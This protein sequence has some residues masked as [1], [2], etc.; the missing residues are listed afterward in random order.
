M[1]VLLFWARL[2]F[3]VGLYVSL[4][5][6]KVEGEGEGEG[7][8]KEMGWKGAYRYCDLAVRRMRRCTLKTPLGCGILSSACR[9]YRRF[10][11]RCGRRLGLVS[12]PG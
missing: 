6:L 10:L 3:P 7:E 12:C 9:S 11:R 1:S 5:R 2:V 4:V 8:G